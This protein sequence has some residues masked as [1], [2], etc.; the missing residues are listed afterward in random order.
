[1]QNKSKINNIFT[2]DDFTEVLFGFFIFNLFTQD[3]EYSITERSTLTTFPTF[4][5]AE[6]KKGKWTERYDEYVTDQFAMRDNFLSLCA[7]SEFILMKKD[8]N[9]VILS[10]ERLV[11]VSKVDSV[12][13]EKNIEYVNN[14]TNSNGL[15]N[16]VI[17]AP[18]AYEIYVDNSVEDLIGDKM[19]Y[20]IDV[21]DALKDCSDEYIYYRTDHHWTSTGA[22]KAYTV[23]DEAV[24]GS[25]QKTS[26]LN[27]PQV[28]TKSFRGTLYSK[29]MTDFV[30]A[31]TI[32]Q[33]SDREDLY[34]KSK[35]DGSSDY[36]VFL[37]GDLPC[38]EFK[39]NADNG[40][41]LLV[42]K[43]SYANSFVQF[44]IDDYEEIVVVDL[45]YYH[46][47]VKDLIA[48]KGLTDCLVLYNAQNFS[49]DN[50]LIYLKM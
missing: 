23:F 15:K 28:I 7:N 39:G 26:R 35:L 18:T 9:D 13:L 25:E 36:S 45:R 3:K 29:A 33:Y 46:L 24:G 17:L 49:T 8:F 6:L 16:S 40:K 21:Y 38:L 47:S 12:Q 11:A 22:L 32:L 5:F 19:N 30:K 42:L 48:E 43:D 34:D 10:S 2:I 4:S 27:E 31:D 20:R 44:L 1:M 14:F 50:N 41:K 37:G